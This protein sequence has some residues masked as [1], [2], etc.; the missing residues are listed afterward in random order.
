MCRACA[1]DVGAAFYYISPSS[2]LS[3][4]HGESEYVLKSLFQQAKGKERNA[5][6]F[7]DEI[8]ALGTAREHQQH[9]RL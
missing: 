4:Y 7:F 5:I 3:K 8:D 9:D 2:I 1:K 6:L